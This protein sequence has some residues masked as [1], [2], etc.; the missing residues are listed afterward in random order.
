LQWYPPPVQAAQIL[1]S[2]PHLNE[3]DILACLVYASEL[4]REGSILSKPHESPG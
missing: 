3:A 4:L 2:Y 1:A